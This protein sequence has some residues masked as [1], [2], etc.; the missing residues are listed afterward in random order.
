LSAQL[1]KKRLSIVQNS[2]AK[3]CFSEHIA[4]SNLANG[5]VH[6]FFN[7]A[8]ATN[9]CALCRESREERKKEREK[10]VAAAALTPASVPLRPSVRYG[11]S[12]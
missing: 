8:A 12:P 5:I 1:A 4:P 7:Q 9:W 6:L 10:E 2:H 11:V 3:V